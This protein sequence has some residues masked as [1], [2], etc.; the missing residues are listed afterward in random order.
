MI[1]NGGYIVK[2]GLALYLFITHFFVASPMASTL[3]HHN[4]QPL[5][6]SA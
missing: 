1:N 5:S 3:L 6:F 4:S 2:S